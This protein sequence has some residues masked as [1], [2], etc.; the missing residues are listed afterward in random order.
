MGCGK[1]EE[2]PAES[3]GTP[4]PAARCRASAPAKA[5]PL[6]IA[7]AY[8]GPPGDGGWTFAHD[9]ARKALEKELRRQDRHQLRREGARGRGRRARVPRHGRPGQQ[10]DLR[11]HLRLHGADAQGRRRREGREVRARHRL[12]AGRQHAHLR[13]AHLPGRVHGRR[14]RGRHE[15][16]RHHRR[17]RLDPYSRK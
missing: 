10:A 2:A 17:G 4:A 16:D 15:Q 13:L 6:K 8:V 5:E 11:H 3:V 9:N 7:F 14:H 12:Q 1:K